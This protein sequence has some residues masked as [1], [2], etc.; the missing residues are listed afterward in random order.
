ME[1]P[2]IASAAAPTRAQRALRKKAEAEE[3]ARKSSSL[4]ARRA[5]LATQSDEIRSIV[6]RE[7]YK[8]M[9]ER[10]RD[11]FDSTL[12]QFMHKL[13]ELSHSGGEY[14]SHI[15]NLVQRLDYNMFY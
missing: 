4:Q 6:A 13:T 15:N 5:R 8:R 7:E 9:I 2:D 12:G 14:Q 3:R 11:N 10:F 1:D